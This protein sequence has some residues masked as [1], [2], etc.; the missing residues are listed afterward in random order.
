M[1]RLNV[2][3]GAQ[4]VSSQASLL[5]KVSFLAY[6]RTH[7][8]GQFQSFASDRFGVVC[9]RDDWSQR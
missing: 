7:T 3:T 5:P 9:G 8:A 1:R 6:L 4:I 2:W